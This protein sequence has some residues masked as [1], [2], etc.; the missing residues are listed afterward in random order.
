MKGQ[1]TLSHLVVYIFAFIIG[2]VVSFIF[3]KFHHDTKDPTQDKTVVQPTIVI[4][5]ATVATTNQQIPIITD[6]TK[7]SLSTS[8]FVTNRPAVVP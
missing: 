7:A 1:K 3:T 4:P 8:G 6:S 2:F 5:K